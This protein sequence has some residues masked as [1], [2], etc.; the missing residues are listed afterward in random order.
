MFGEKEGGDS[1][2]RQFSWDVNTP[3]PN[4]EVK[5]FLEDGLSAWI[6]APAVV[7]FEPSLPREP[8]CE[9]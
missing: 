5:S 8:E 6:L 7:I 4:V 1:S 2:S 9:I 3:E